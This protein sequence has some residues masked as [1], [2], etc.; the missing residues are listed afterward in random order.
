[1]IA[2]IEPCLAQQLAKLTDKTSLYSDI[3]EYHDLAIQHLQNHSVATRS[4]QKL[5]NQ[6]R[7]ERN[8]NVINCVRCV[9]EFLYLV[10]EY[11]LFL[12]TMK[13]QIEHVDNLI[14]D[15]MLYLNDI[16]AKSYIDEMKRFKTLSV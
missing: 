7:E 10:N 12:H 8:E 1:M 16:T 6:H 9:T 4:T 11:G 15:K 13:D 5:V 2:T 14:S 3:V